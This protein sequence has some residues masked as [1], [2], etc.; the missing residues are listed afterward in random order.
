[1]AEEFHEEEQLG[2]AYDGRLM[3]R[4]LQY[5]RP[6]KW[7]LMLCI[8]LILL[9][10][11][12]ELAGP[13]IIKVAID[14]HINVWD[15]PYAVYPAHHSIDAGFLWNEERYVRL[16]PD[17]PLPVG[18]APAQVIEEGEQLLL[19]P[20]WLDEAKGWTVSQQGDTW[21]VQQG[22][23]QWVATPLDQEALTQFRQQDTAALFQL[24]LLYFT[25]LLF[26]FGLGYLQQYYL[27]KT[28]Q[29]IIFNLRQEI[30][31]H[32][33]RLPLGFY[34]KNP[35]GRLVTRTTNDTE[36]INEM[37]SSVVVNLF[38]DVFI[39]LGI[40]LIMLQ[41]NVKLALL[42]FCTLP[43]IIA[44]SLVYKKLARQAFREVKLKIA[45]INATLNENITGMRI[46]H[47]FKREEAQHDQF[48]QIN[49]SHL[50]SSLKELRT[51]AIFRPFMDFIYAFG[52][53]LLIW[54]GGHDVLG[55]TLQFGVL[56]AFIDY[57]NRFFQPI[58]N[59]SERYTV[60]QSAMA[61]AERIFQLLDQQDTLPDPEKPIEIPKIEGR[62]QFQNVYFAYQNDEY[63]LK[64]ISFTVEPGETVAF[65]GAT[66]AGKSSIINLLSRFYDIQKGHILIDGIDIRQMRKADLRRQIGVV[67]QDVFLFSGDIRSNIRLNQTN[68]PDEEVERVARYVNA[69]T[70]IEK[71]PQ[72]YDEPVTER[73][74]TLS[75]GQ[76][77][78][79]SF[80]RTLLVDPAILVLDEA[81][82]NID[83]ETELLI[84]DSLKK[85]SHGRTTFIIAHRLS[86]IQHADKII[87]LHKGEIREM[88]N[89]Q[90]LLQQ[91]GL[92]Y[93]LYQL[94]YKEQFLQQGKGAQQLGLA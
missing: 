73:G 8:G 70:F 90:E 71:L 64:D 33:Q 15:Q 32:L 23:E 36:A 26:G 11:V 7:I 22:T 41:L 93:N 18:A 45:R 83:T 61:S 17:S 40:M 27:Q 59:L 78:L 60:L 29:R 51:A 5:A 82:A 66:G 44:S 52:L 50:Q 9:I 55:G 37:F 65:V 88:G 87:V 2:K 46:V 49:R 72:Q 13:Y 1:M 74:S 69:H 24:A 57:I 84:Q 12:S 42:S 10:T 34:D 35:V 76:R 77:Q 75:A 53:S 89:H 92:Y 48:D 54:F 16:Q 58:N 21:L 30:F 47:I 38:K 43:L 91:Q 79:L 67:L 3:R 62:V 81:T 63:V 19:V 39:L 31:T 28:S 25:L 80:A 85:V 68:I 94:Q 56:Y 20:A 86:T 4:L 6:Y 14:E